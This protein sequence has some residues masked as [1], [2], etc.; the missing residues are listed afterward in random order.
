MQ[1]MLRPP[2]ARVPAAA[3]AANAEKARALIA[4]IDGGD[5][6]EETPE[7]EAARLRDWARDLVEAVEG[8]TAPE[9]PAP[10]AAPALSAPGA[11]AGDPP[12]ATPMA[13]AADP[14]VPKAPA[15]APEAKHPAASEAV[16]APSADNL[17]TSVAPEIADW[18]MPAPALRR[19]KVRKVAAKRVAAEPAPKAKA[20]PSRRARP[21]NLF[22][23]AAP[24]MADWKVPVTL[25]VQRIPQQAY[26]R[27]ALLLTDP[28]K[29]PPSDAAT[30]EPAA[31][32]ETPPEAEAAPQPEAR[33]PLPPPLP[34]PPFVKPANWDEVRSM[35]GR[36]VDPVAMARE[37]PAVIAMT[38]V[39]RPTLDQAAAFRGLP[40]GQ[41][42][43][44]HRV[45]RQM[46]QGA[47]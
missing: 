10:R 34:E 43:A 42:R 16:D 18:D 23:A 8:R 40:A 11:T 25:P 38:L 26:M 17:F 4:L 13:A 47:R 2:K 5:P 7:V 31:A 45:L 19:P 15:P 22:T 27:P 6:D 44:V 28:V 24:R 9:T 20:D 3:V 29:V 30:P 35:I 46:E 12:P 32:P 14:A 1:P 33:R 39:G 36:T 41:V 21:A 37:H